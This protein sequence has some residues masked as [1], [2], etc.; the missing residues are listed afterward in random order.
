MVMSVRAITAASHGGFTNDQIGGTT[1]FPTDAGP[2]ASTAIWPVDQV[3]RERTLRMKFNLMESAA[4][5]PKSA[6][7]GQ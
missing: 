5:E 6:S 7:C 1:P 3:G 4:C 2:D